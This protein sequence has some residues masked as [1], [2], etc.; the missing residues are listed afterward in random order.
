ME[1][2]KGLFSYYEGPLEE[3]L[4][5]AIVTKEG[6]IKSIIATVSKRLINDLIL[7]GIDTDVTWKHTIDNSAVRHAIKIH[8]ND[9]ESLRGQSQLTV[10][11]MLMIP[12]IVSS[13]DTI[14]TSKNRRNQDTILYTKTMESGDTYFFAEEVR[15][16]RHELAASTLY[17]R[18]KENS[19]TL[20]G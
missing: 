20:I 9:K 5:A 17:K 16:G 7:H 3:F 19:P 14:T 10:S 6:L 4:K 1:T 8:G 11:D 2:E 18:K 15:M 12:T 13:Y